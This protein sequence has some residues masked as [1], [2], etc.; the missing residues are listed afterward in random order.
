MTG[1]GLR[2]HTDFCVIPVL[3]RSG[4]RRSPAPLRFPTIVLGLLVSLSA[5]C[6]TPPPVVSYEDDQISVRLIHDG[7]AS[8]PHRHP[9]GLARG[10]LVRALSD[11]AVADRDGLLTGF[12]KSSNVERRVF[13]DSEARLIAPLLVRALSQAAPSQLVTFHW[14]QPNPPHGQVVT[15]GGLFVEGPRLVVI[16]ANH[17]ATPGLSYEG[18]TYESDSRAAPLLPF[19]PHT[20]R[21][22]MREAALRANLDLVADRYRFDDVGQAVA[23]DLERLSL[24]GEITQP[25]QSPAEGFAN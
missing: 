18:I 7:R 20:F 23:I 10:L 2:A 3:P 11:L 15:S 6:A 25:A 17:R 1:A 9:F 16:V 24:I 21:L 8:S 13:S 12:L 14:K 4:R 22:R 19:R 5:G